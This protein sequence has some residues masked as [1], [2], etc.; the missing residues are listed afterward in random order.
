LLYFANIGNA[1]MRLVLKKEK[2]IDF[3]FDQ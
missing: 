2:G 1:L 3:S